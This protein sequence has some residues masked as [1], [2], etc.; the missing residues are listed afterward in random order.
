V[1]GIA[2]AI[3]PF[4]RAF[5]A[6]RA[7]DPSP[8]FKEASYFA[9]T[10]ASANAL[11][12]LV[13]AGRKRATTALCWAY[14]AEGQALP[15]PGDLN[16][17]TDWQGKPLCVIETGRVDVVAFDAVSAEFA[18]DEGEGDGSLGYWRQVHQAF[19][20]RECLRLG[21]TPD[22]AMPVVCERFA[23]VYSTQPAD[24][25]AVILPRRGAGVWLRRLAPA[26]LAAFQVYRHDPEVGRYQ[27]WTAMSDGEA[28]AFLADVNSAPL[29]QPGHW[30]QIAICAAGSNA[31]I[32][33]IGMLIAA[34]A[35][36]AEI[37]FSLARPWQGRGLASA[38]LRCAIEWVFE[39]STVPRVVAITDAR[40]PP[41]IRL[42]ERLGFTRT[43]TEVAV[44]RGLPCREHHYRFDRL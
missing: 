32:G 3:E 1:N 18:A 5:A 29:L 9:D 38:A 7:D 24:P 10:E 30:S 39:H 34:D 36:H 35:S 25:G 2:P 31:L 28:L 41:S 22:P 13:L 33:D 42:L 12:Q 15:L 17:V 44:F 4:W 23:L 8:R 14:E 16:V 26:D 37:G 43:A 27:G 11:A 21:R 40:N 6:T 19:F 20:E